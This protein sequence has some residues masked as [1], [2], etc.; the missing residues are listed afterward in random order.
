MSISQHNFFLW[1]SFG[2]IL[3]RQTIDYLHW[4]KSILNFLVSP[5]IIL[6]YLLCQLKPANIG[7]TAFTWSNYKGSELFSLEIVAPSC[8][9]LVVSRHLVIRISCSFFVSFVWPSW[10]A[11]NRLIALYQ[12]D[13][14]VFCIL[15][16]D[17]SL[18]APSSL[19]IDGVNSAEIVLVASFCVFCASW[20]L[21][22]LEWLHWFWST[23]KFS[24][25]LF[26]LLSISIRLIAW[27]ILVNRN[28]SC[29]FILMYLLCNQ[30][31]ASILGITLIL[32]DFKAS[33]FSL[34]YDSFSSLLHRHMVDVN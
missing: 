10:T 8:I 23:L 33:C 2:G 27:S 7:V 29:G 11:S 28:C 1:F 25:L 24:A 19:C 34:S 6:L 4:F 14:K 26:Q 12:I 9:N 31:A 5:I 17:S 15:F 32:V 30:E 21:Q 13:S 3:R 22:T 16:F 18:P 20:S